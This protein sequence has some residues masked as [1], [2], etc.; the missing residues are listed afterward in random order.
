MGLVGSAGA[1]QEGAYGPKKEICNF[2]QKQTS[3]MPISHLLSVLL[4]SPAAVEGSYTHSPGTAGVSPK[5]SFLLSAQ[6][7]LLC[8]RRPL[9]PH[10][11][12]K[13]TRK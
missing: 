12:C 6:S 4:I 5:H 13:H 7:L 9:Q 1:R 2:C 11:K 10:P 8:C 3:P